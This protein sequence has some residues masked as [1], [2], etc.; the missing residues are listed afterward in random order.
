MFRKDIRG[1][2]ALA[3][4]A[5]L[6]YHFR[7]PGFSAG[8]AGVDVFFVVSGYLMTWLLVHDLEHGRHSATSFYLSRARR[9]VPA[10][11]TLS[12]ILMLVGWWVSLPDDYARFATHALASLWFVSNHVYLGES[13]YFDFAATEK[14][15][16]HTWSLS[17]EWQFYLLL[18][19]LLS[20]C[21]RWRPHR[22]FIA[23]AYVVFA[24]ASL[25]L[26]LAVPGDLKST[27]FFL[28]L[29]RMW[30]LIAGGLTMLVIPILHG[31]SSL[32]W[33]FGGSGAVG[34]L[35]TLLLS[36][37]SV[38]WPG[39]WTL[40][41]VLSTAGVLCAED[42]S[43]TVLGSHV[44]G[45]VGDRS[46]SLYLW[47]WPIVVVLTDLGAERT[48]QLG[49]G[50]PASILLAHLSYQMIEQPFRSKFPGFRARDAVMAMAF[51]AVSASLA[52]IITDAGVPARMPAVAEGA[53]AE[54]RNRFSP[55]R[56]CQRAAT[57]PWD[58]CR[59]GSGPVGAILIGDSHADAVA[60]SL[61]QVLTEQQRSLVLYV[62]PSCPTLI[63]AKWTPGVFRAGQHC[64]AF[65]QWAL[66]RVDE[67]ANGVP[68][69]LVARSSAYLYGLT[70]SWDPSPPGPAIH[71][72]RPRGEVDAEFLDEYS[73]AL[74]QTVCQLT[75]RRPVFQVRPIPEMA[76]N[77]P[78]AIAR[79]LMRR[80]LR[81]PAIDLS[82]YWARHQTVIAVQESVSNHCGGRTLDPVPHLCDSSHCFAGSAGRP[83]YYDDDHLSEFGNRRLL[84]MFRQM[85][86]V[87]K[88]R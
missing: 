53:A 54:A 67:F 66:A 8:F 3:V 59:Y 19:L 58:S 39:P 10:L 16:L 62:Y 48:V 74:Y 71:F 32:R 75:R 45:W 30:E 28:L 46:Y 41:P 79:S 55:L 84:P 52:L 88:T 38:D 87:S 42:R 21:W 1:L 78:R 57:G 27:A 22:S 61:A 69:V 76:V 65:N 81:M 43:P 44:L 7:V 60:S 77:A 29:T 86:A 11:V 15:M 18:P 50:L 14:W 6:F 56:K 5:V 17:V 49:V 80:D 20:V 9:I 34:M 25:S 33:V 63:G 24:L 68:V 23:A 51:A 83:W 70:E 2:R 4:L 35:L 13:G 26:M 82:A 40:L 72:S 73:K 47:H 36:P 64:E 12:A 37:S 85:F 31:R